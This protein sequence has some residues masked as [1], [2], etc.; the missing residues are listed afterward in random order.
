MKRELT[1]KLAVGP[2]SVEAVEAVYD[3]SERL[4][5]QLML[6]ASKNQ[7][8]HSS[9][10]VNNWTTST[11]ADHLLKL[12]QRYAAAD[13]VICR[14]HC[15]PGFNGID[16]IQDTYRTID[17]DLAAGFDLIHVDLCHMRADRSQRLLESKQI[18]EYIKK[19]R[20][21]TLIE[22][23]TDEIGSIDDDLDQVRDEVD[24]FCSFCEPEFYVVRTGSLVK[25]TRQ[26]GTFD[27][28][29]SSRLQTL[30][31]ERGTKLKE[32]NAD[33]LTG[34]DVNLRQGAVDAINI[35]PEI[36]VVQ[37]RY[38]LNQSRLHGISVDDFIECSYNSM[39]WS[40][41]IIDEKQPPSREQCA[42]IAGHYNFTSAAYKDLCNNLRKFQPN[43]EQDIVAEIQK[44][45]TVYID[46]L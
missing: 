7:I 22:I 13:V 4:G 28:D 40:K 46:N 45:L 30:L 23:G 9:G 43:L 6:I 34:A 17:A 21:E 31:N 16:D 2:M 42:I 37:T 41:W 32:H 18:I 20:P 3:L 11:F 19:S 26:V 12:K 38:V 35:A 36:G 14:D 15:G 27:R 24:F 5:I 8:D 25:E 44:T 10:Y 29:H 33:Y 1:A 39:K